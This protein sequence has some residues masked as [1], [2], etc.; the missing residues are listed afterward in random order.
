MANSQY[1]DKDF[2][3][4]TRTQPKRCGKP[5][6]FLGEVAVITIVFSCLLRKEH[7]EFSL[8][9]K[10]FGRPGI[11]RRALTGMV[12]GM[13]KWAGM[14]KVFPLFSSQH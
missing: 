13:A 2:P 10:G 1:E 5:R 7:Y 14:C 12:G 4:V 6:A 8:S 9:L 3:K 11:D